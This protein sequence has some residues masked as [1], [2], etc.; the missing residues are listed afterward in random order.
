MTITSTTRGGIC[1]I[2]FDRPEAGQTYDD[3]TIADLAMAIEAAAAEPTVR[4]LVI[5]GADRN[6]LAGPDPSDLGRTDRG[7]GAE[8]RIGRHMGLLHL[9]DTCQKPVV[10]RIDGVAGGLGVGLAAAADLAVAAEEAEF[11]VQDVRH[12]V[13]PTAVAPWLLRAV[14]T[15]QATRLLLT[16]DRI[17]ASEARAMGLVHETAPRATLDTAVD[18][19]L[20][21]LLKAAP[22]TIAATKELIAHVGEPLDV[23]VMETAGRLGLALQ[24]RATGEAD[25]TAA[26]RPAYA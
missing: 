21:G 1:R 13:I 23:E 7:P 5:T 12:G 11:V 22:G 20:V 4:A 15:R 18:R 25:G 3:E 2:A 8:A 19:F 6:F 24:A 17:R 9:V 14:G 16:G 10:A 26:P